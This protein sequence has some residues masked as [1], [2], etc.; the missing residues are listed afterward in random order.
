MVNSKTL[1]K[2]S[3]IAKEL[4][5]DNREYK[6]Y[7]C[8]GPSSSVAG[9]IRVMN[10]FKFYEVDENWDIFVPC[11]YNRVE[12]ELEEINPDNDHQIFLAIPGCDVMVGKTS[13]WKAL[14]NKYGREMASTIIPETF[15]LNNDDHVNL[16]KE[17]Y[18]PDKIYILKNKRQR[19]EGIKLTKDINEIVSDDMNYTL[20]QKYIND[21]L[22]VNNR[23]LNLRIYLLLTLKDGVLEGHLNRFGTCIY[24]NKDYIEGS[25]EFESNIT[26]YNLNL[27]IYNKNPLTFKQLRTY[28]LENGYEDPDILF[29]RI[30][31]K[32]RLLCDAI[33]TSFGNENLKNNLCA[34]IFG[35]DFIVNKN[36]EPYLLECNKGPEMAPRKDSGFATIINNIEDFYATEELVERAYPDGYK[37]G[38]GLK[39]QRDMFKYLDIIKMKTCNNVGFYKIY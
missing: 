2:F 6:T 28:L 32:V 16:F 39:A 12:L 7:Y 11:G 35:L 31:N 33:K 36:L 37:T 10:R 1:R 9:Y 23:K 5:E 18:E 24:S 26:S 17:I 14:E 4:E 29:S 25:M 15:V 8:G 3:E 21:I 27:E 13:L 30:D 19:K 34:Q 38:N 20:V 22:L